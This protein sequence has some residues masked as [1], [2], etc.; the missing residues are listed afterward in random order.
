[1][2]R[3]WLLALVVVIGA[4]CG[5]SAAPAVTE[6]TVDSAWAR[7]TPPGALNGVVYLRI[8]SPSEDALVSARVSHKVAHAVKIEDVAGSAGTSPMANM[9]EM[10]EDG[11]MT[12]VP[13]DSVP[14]VAG[15]PAVFEPG[16]KHIIL[17]PLA[18]PLVEGGHF[19]LTM[20]FASGATRSVDVVVSSNP[21]D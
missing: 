17:S 7:P 15:V 1:M 20:R 9:P 10:A 4:A 6:L 21:P 14:L 12:A 16:G 3:G 13:I 8:T 18:D 2:R 19:K 11:E 5:S